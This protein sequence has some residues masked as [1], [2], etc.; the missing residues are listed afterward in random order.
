MTAGVL[1]RGE[2]RPGGVERE[3]CDPEVL[4]L[5]RRRSLARLRREIEPVEP[6]ALAR[7]LPAWQGVGGRASGLDRLPGGHR[8]ARGPA[9]RGERPRARRP[10]RACAWLRARDARRARRGR[11]GRLGRRRLAGPRRRPRRPLPTGPPRA[12]ARRHEPT[13]PTDPTA[14]RADAWIHAGIAGAAR[15]ARRRVLPRAIGERP[16]GRRRRA[17]AAD[18]PSERSSMRSGTSSGPARS[19][20][21]RSR[22]CARC[23]GR[24][25]AA[26]AG[27]RARGS[28]LRCALGP[29]EAAGRWSLV[30]ETR[31][32]GGRAR[33]R[34]GTERDGA[35]C[36]AG[37]GAARAS[38]GPHAG[39]G[40]VGGH[41]RWASGPCIRS[42]AT[43]EERGRV[44]RGYFV[45]GLGGAQ[46]ALPGAVDRLRATREP[47]DDAAAGS[48]AARTIVLAATD[49]ANPYGAA[50]AW[51]REEERGSPDAVPRGR[52]V[53]RAR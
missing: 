11:R 48:S 6:A 42:C 51:P 9:D 43:M 26:R 14:E 31:T 29:P 1:L 16:R 53:R 30:A 49:P 45:E 34:P 40:R 18:R 17:L 39:R 12:P 33:R 46:F 24:G 15:G 20:T 37:D 35:P 47:G 28:A 25:P 13:E 52:R 3:W 8:A 10:A 44:R 21:T 38:R 41:R 27:R 50:L 19:R 36:R 5:L 7:F 4:R 23:T 22:R 2:F 32:D